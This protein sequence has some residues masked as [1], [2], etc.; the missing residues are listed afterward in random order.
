MQPSW[1]RGKEVVAEDFHGLENYLL[2]RWKFNEDDYG[3]ES[4]DLES[5]MS[6]ETE[7]SLFRLTLND[8]AGVTQLGHPVRLSQPLRAEVR[9]GE[10]PFEFDAEVAVN[11]AGSEL[12]NRLSDDPRKFVLR[13][14]G[15]PS[16]VEFA[17][18]SLDLGA[19]RYSPEDGLVCLARPRVR[20]LNALR[21]LDLDWES[22]IHPWRSAIEQRTNALRGLSVGATWRGVAWAQELGQLAFL[23]PT[24]LVS[25]LARRAC[26]LKSLAESEPG[27]VVAPLL[28][29]TGLVA[30]VEGD[31]I[32]KYLAELLGLRL[33]PAGLEPQAAPA[34]GPSAPQPDVKL[35]WLPP[36]TLLARFATSLEGK[37]VALCIPAG[38]SPPEAMEVRGGPAVGGFRV[39]EELLGVKKGDHMVYPLRATP[40]EGETF[41][42]APVAKEAADGVYVTW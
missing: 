14:N 12:F 21:P 7:G 24:M 32:P 30:G 18:G 27:G 2:S 42:F 35:K 22:W 31:D 16:D 5:S 1:Y 36:D 20:K 41:R 39:K 3:V 23:W 29:V 28:E 25:E 37:K 34:E 8:L 40:R 19:Y 13:L 17:G 15:N 26:Y 11:P 9:V 38:A 6:V 10:P 33:K 4:F